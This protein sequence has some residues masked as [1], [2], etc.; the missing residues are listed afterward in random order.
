M[1]CPKCN[2]ISFDYNQT[3][4]KCKKSLSEVRG[5]MNHFPFKPCPISLADFT[6]KEPAESVS[7]DF[8]MEET[9][10]LEFSGSKDFDFQPESA[11]SQLSLEDESDDLSL[12]FD[13][14]AMDDAAPVASQKEQTAAA[15]DSLE[16]GLDFSFEDESDELSL[17]F[18]E[19]MVGDAAS[20]SPPPDET[21][22]LED[23]LEAGLDF[24]F[25][26]ESNELSLDFDEPVIG[27]AASEAPQTETKIPL[28]ESIEETLDLTFKE[29]DEPVQAP[30]EPALDEDVDSGIELKLDDEDDHEKTI[31]LE[32]SE[33]EVVTA[34]FDLDDLSME[35][36]G[37][38]IKNEQGKNISSELE[39]MDL[40]L[41]LEKPNDK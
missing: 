3:C 8:G 19:P 27:D 4:P 18:D 16:A 21:V 10:E 26:D 7:M 38:D 32:P 39:V 34:A 15:E 29:D 11:S 6:G 1:K 35:E 30:E 37:T 13:E 12:D 9:A 24:S 22:A 40:D 36:P 5:K 25:E 31:A 17:D 28:E 2:Y 41:D 23:N 33:E 14:L 20:K